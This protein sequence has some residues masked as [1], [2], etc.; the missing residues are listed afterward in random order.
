MQQKL[1][2]ILSNHSLLEVAAER[3]PHSHGAIEL[4]LRSFP[5]MYNLWRGK[6]S[7]T[8]SQVAQA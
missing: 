2:A 3:G 4:L 5:S 7:L 1:V 8:P 6:D